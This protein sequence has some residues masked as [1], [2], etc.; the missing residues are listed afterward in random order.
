MVIGKWFL[1]K[2]AN[3]FIYHFVLCENIQ[4]HIYIQKII[5]VCISQTVNEKRGC[6][7][8]VRYH[9]WIYRW[10][11]GCVRIIISRPVTW[12]SDPELRPGSVSDCSRDYVVNAELNDESSRPRIFQHRTSVANSYVELDTVVSAE[13]DDPPMSN[14]AFSGS[15][16]TRDERHSNHRET[17]GW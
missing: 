10:L 4:S 17:P 2:I 16:Q 8:D 7:S 15:P 1:F 12:K 9:Q 11:Q 14:L 6:T 13:I 3:N 5:W